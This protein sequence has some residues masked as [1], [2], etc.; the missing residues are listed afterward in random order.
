MKKRTAGFVGLF[1]FVCTSILYSVGGA[2]ASPLRSAPQDFTSCSDLVPPTRLGRNIEDINDLLL[3]FTQNL[4]PNLSLAEQRRAFEMYLKMRFGKADDSVSESSFISI[5][6]EIE[7]HPEL[8]KEKLLFRNY[9][10]KVVENSYTPP[11][12][13]DRF[14]KGNTS[15]ARQV[16]TNLLQMESNIALWKKI[17]QYEESEAFQVQ[18]KNKDEKKALKKQAR[19]HFNAYFEHFISF[20]EISN[21][22]ERTVKERVVV[23][24]KKL[25]AIHKE[26]TKAQKNTLPIRQAMVDLVHTIGFHD[27][28]LLK[29]LKEGDALEKVQA[30]KKTLEKRDVFAQELGYENGFEGVL[31]KWN[32][33]LPTGVASKK[34]KDETDYREKQVLASRKTIDKE[35]REK[36][37]HLSFMEAPFRGCLGN[38]CSSYTYFKTA[39]DPNYHYFTLTDSQGFSSGHITLVLGTGTLKDNRGT[40][41]AFIDKIQNIQL[42]NL[43]VFIE[44]VRRSVLEKGYV[45]TLTKDGGD[46]SGLSNLQN[47]SQFVEES[48]SLLESPIAD[49]KPHPHSYHFENGSSR[50]EKGLTIYPVQTLPL[51]QDIHLNPLP[52]QEPWQASFDIHNLIQQLKLIKKD[53]IRYI[54]TMASFKKVNLHLDSSFFDIIHTWLIDKKEDFKIRKESLLF[55]WKEDSIPLRTLLSHFETREQV[56]L[57]QNILDTPRHKDFLKTNEKSPLELLPLLEAHPKVYKAF[58]D[59]TDCLRLAL[60]QGDKETIVMLFERGIDI[61]AKDNLGNTALH[62]ATERGDKDMAALLLDKGADINAKNNSGYTALLYAAER[63]HKDIITLLLDRGADIHAKANFGDTALHRATERGHKDV[64]TLLLDRGADI[65]AKDNLGN[66]ALLYATLRRNKD[67]AALLLDRGA[68]IHAKDNLGKTALYYATRMG[69][70]DIIT[71]L[72]DRGADINAKDNLGKTALHHATERRDKDII[73]L[74]LDRGADIH[75]KDNLGKTALL[76]ATLRRNKDIITLLLD[77]GADA[78]INAIDNFGNTALLYATKSGHKDMITLLLDKGADIHVIDNYGNTA[79]HIATARG[80][81][82]IITLLLDRGADADIN[83]K[84]NFGDTALYIA[85]ARGDKDMVTLL[86]DRGADAE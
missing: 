55:K 30:F 73:T 78:D 67:M 31:E 2:T 24:Y 76:Y 15:K 72:L 7:N 33:V 3:A 64:V 18:G 1:L 11:Q 13:L 38:D 51:H 80:D 14:L 79:L 27:S 47:I 66:T 68:D 5:Q 84:N 25:L 56:I 58:A 8:L 74:L 28:Y 26:L 34:L 20:Q 49:F 6:E 82:D 69:D 22:S 61:H 45:L 42:N 53:P 65:N 43:P 9:D 86:L 81:M 59:S 19:E 4:I 54:A 16:Q 44:G 85:T 77:R 29:I 46:S 40:K 41:L 60:K 57:I 10:W 23:L 48:I 36:I 71:L 21:H 70:K 52:V 35:V 12:D 39:L 75:A 83:A 50:V 63:G 37:R 62:I 32:I 17:L